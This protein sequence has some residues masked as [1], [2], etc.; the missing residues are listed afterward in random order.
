MRYWLYK[1]NVEGGPA[2]YWG[3]WRTNVFASR[4]KEIEWGGDYSTLSPEVHKHL[5]ESVE[6]GDVIAAYQTDQRLVVGFCRITRMSGRA[7]QRKIWLTPIHELN[8]GF[9]IHERKHGSPL[10][11]STAVRGMLMLRELDKTE[12]ETLVRLSGAP[13]R[14]LRGRGPASGRT[15]RTA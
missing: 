10:E 12:M 8:P 6:A 13:A 1:C 4:K 9:A 5:R 7:G 11:S 2:G 14:V 15:Q 3:D